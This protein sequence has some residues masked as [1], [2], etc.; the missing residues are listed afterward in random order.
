MTG[1]TRL[2]A[3]DLLAALRAGT[4]TSAGLVEA[5]LG[6]IA[7]L[8]P[9]L[10]AVVRLHPDARRQAAA[11]DAARARGE[12][13][14]PLHGLPLTIKDG[15]RVGGVRT[16]FG[17]PGAPLITQPGDCE[18]VRRVRAAG[19]VVLGRTALPLAMF[20]W[21]CRTPLRAECNNPLD[22]RRTPGG[23]SG[24][25]AA[26]LAAHLTP[27]EIGSDLAGS[28]RY[29]AHCCGVT[30]LRASVGL[31]PISDIGP[32]GRT[33]TAPSAVSVGPMA[34]TLADLRLL[35]EVMLADDDRNKAPPPPP[36]DRLRVAVTP[37]PTDVVP[38]DATL[39]ALDR[40]ADRLRAAG[41]AVTVLDAPPFPFADGFAL[42]GLLVG[43]EMRRAMPLPLRVAPVNRLAAHFLVTHRLG[44]GRMSDWTLR[45]VRATP[46][47]YRAGLARQAELRERVAA[48]FGRFDL[49][50]LPVSPGPALVRQPLGRPI[51]HRGEAVPYADYLGGYLCPTAVVGTPAVTFPV[52]AG[53]GGMPV[54]VQVHAAR[55]ADRWLVR[56]AENHLAGMM[57]P[58]QLGV[59]SGRPPNN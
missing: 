5:F 47:D 24:G 23:S 26:A 41:H 34:R 45:G 22:P 12:P 20:D 27:L 31:L 11:A 16:T 15:F 46:A 32:D 40:F 7:R 35:A 43:A 6:R 48:F 29:P 28:I 19:A 36:G 10:H 9:H 52:G 54:G 17:V 8:D 49:W 13:L 55:F 38:D 50:A 57:V 14:G 2:S 56:A 33:P 1:P 30:S 3:A 53:E 21:Q 59:D 51:R 18:V 4:V 25:S 39:A 42:W 44:R 58:P 37:R